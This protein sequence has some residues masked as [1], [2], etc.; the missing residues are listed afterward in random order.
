M[1]RETA[2]T[3]TTPTTNTPI[4][5][6]AEEHASFEREGYCICPSFLTPEGLAY[7]QSRADYVWRNK[8]KLTQEAW[9]MNLHQVLPCDD[10]WMWRL[11]THPTVL[12]IVQRHLG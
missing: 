1:V 9:L 7:L 4:R 11:G 12:G 3:T 8:S 10:N 2:L 6:G 5:Y